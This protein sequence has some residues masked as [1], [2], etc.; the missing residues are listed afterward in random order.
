MATDHYAARIITSPPT[1]K[2][3]FELFSLDQID[4]NA[5]EVIG[6][7]ADQVRFGNWDSLWVHVP[8]KEKFFEIN[9]KSLL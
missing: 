8:T 2:G 6:Q 1:L 3:N 7:T 9:C 4:F 5:I